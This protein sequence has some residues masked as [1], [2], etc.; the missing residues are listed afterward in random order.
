[1]VKYSKRKYPTN[2]IATIPVERSKTVLP[3][4][5]NVEIVVWKVPEP[6]SPHLFKY[7]LF[8]GKD[9]RRFVGFDNKR[10]KG[11]HRHL[12]G[13]E[14]PYMFTTTHALLSDFRKEIITRRQ[15]P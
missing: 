8:Y 3:D 13:E 5:A 11:D 15:K 9:G 1:M 6:V 12:D 14:H 7:R 4:G 10:G 2:M